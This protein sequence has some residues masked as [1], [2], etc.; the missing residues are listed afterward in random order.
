MDKIEKILRGIM[1]HKPVVP[2]VADKIIDEALSAIKQVFLE[3]LGKD[4]D[5]AFNNLSPNNEEYVKGY[6]A[7]LAKIKSKIGGVK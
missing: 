2:A 7:C 1:W 5:F 3:T 4:I 6:N